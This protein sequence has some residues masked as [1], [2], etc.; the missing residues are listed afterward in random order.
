MDKQKMDR[1]MD[2]SCKN[3]YTG[4]DWVMCWY[5]RIVHAIA[6]PL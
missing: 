6:W 3:I 4:I 5:E 1:W 2:E